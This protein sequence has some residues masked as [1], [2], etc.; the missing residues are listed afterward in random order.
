MFEG[1]FFKGQAL[2]IDRTNMHPSAICLFYCREG[3]QIG[4]IT[5]V[6]EYGQMEPEIQWIDQSRVLAAVDGV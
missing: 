2:Y 6:K 5:N 4:V 3:N 1:P